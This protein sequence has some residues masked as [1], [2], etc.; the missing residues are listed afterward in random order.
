MQQVCNQLFIG[1]AERPVIRQGQD[2]LCRAFIG[3]LREDTFGEEAGTPL[4][5]LVR[6]LYRTFDIR[7]IRNPNDPL[8]EK[9]LETKLYKIAQELKEQQEDA[10]FENNTNPAQKR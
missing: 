4:Q 2:E 5:T 3:S 7:N 8:Q 9:S 10:F 1:E 6:F